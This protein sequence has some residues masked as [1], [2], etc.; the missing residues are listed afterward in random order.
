M[1]I[2]RTHISAIAKAINEQTQ[3]GHAKSIALVAKA[4]GYKD[5]NALMGTLK[6][7]QPTLLDTVTPSKTPAGYLYELTFS[8]LSD[9]PNMEDLSLQDIA[10]EVTDGDCVG[11]YGDYMKITKTPINRGTLDTLATAFGSSPDFFFN[12]DEEDAPTRFQDDLPEMLSR[13]FYGYRGYHGDDLA[14]MLSLLRTLLETMPGVLAEKKDTEAHKK[15]LG[16]LEEAEDAY[17]EHDDA[18][19]AMAFTQLALLELL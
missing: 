11:G 6:Q 14:D 9:D 13:V 5:G 8:F 7:E 19:N 12:P 1:N 3:M 17:N 10:Y 18:L 15:A 16:F 4:L 2:T